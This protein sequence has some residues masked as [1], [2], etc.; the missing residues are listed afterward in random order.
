M[1]DTIIK[2]VILDEVHTRV[3]QPYKY[4]TDVLSYETGLSCPEPTLTQ[5]N[6]AEQT[7]INYIVAQFTQ[8]GYLPNAAKLPTYGDFSSVSDFREALELINQ[9]EDAFNSLPAAARAHFGNSPG[10]FLDYMQNSPELS[11]LTSLGIDDFID[12]STLQKPDESPAPLP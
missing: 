4:S 3:Y 6:T 12:V 11:L 10:D 2:P 7:D 8:T 9:A 1:K 5:Q